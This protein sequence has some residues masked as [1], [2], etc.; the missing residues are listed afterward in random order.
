M[1]RPVNFEHCESEANTD[2]TWEAMRL[3]TFIATP[4]PPA[5]AVPQKIAF[6]CVEPRGNKARTKHPS[7]HGRGGL[8]KG[9]ES[10]NKMHPPNLSLS[11]YRG[12]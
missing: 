4:A 3:L 10:R 2:G 6:A 1:C 8:G 11:K 12:A 7:D 5:P 9:Q